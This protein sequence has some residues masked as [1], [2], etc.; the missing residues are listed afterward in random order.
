MAQGNEKAVGPGAE[1]ERVEAMSSELDSVLG[2]GETEERALTTQTGNHGG[3]SHRLIELAIERGVDVGALERLV[4]LHNR[5]IARQSK[6]LYEEKFAEMQRSFGKIVRTRE[7]KDGT[8]RKMYAFAPLEDIVAVVG[9]TIAD[10]GFRYRFEEERIDGTDEKRIWCVV[11][12]HGHEERTFIDVP[13]PPASK[14]TNAIQQRGSASSYGKRYAFL[15]AFGLTLS[16]EDDDARSISMMEADAMITSLVAVESA[17][18]IEELKI[19]FKAAFADAGTEAQK[20]LAIATKN[21]RKE[22]LNAG[23]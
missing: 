12:G 20:M 11:T 10:Y 22:A 4:D 15:A 18:T 9:S 21:R 8:G 2:K 1:E 6:A 3:A 19:A 5:E 7:A 23:N 16:D 13:I 17:Q 14:M